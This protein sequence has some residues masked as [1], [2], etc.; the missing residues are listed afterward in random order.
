MKEQY[1]PFRMKYKGYI[2]TQTDGEVIISDL[3]RH[4]VLTIKIQKPK[5]HRE[6]AELF[7]F[8]ARIYGFDEG[9]G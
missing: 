5:T 4:E 3:F 6:L 8:N 2:I 7:E 1:F 9:G